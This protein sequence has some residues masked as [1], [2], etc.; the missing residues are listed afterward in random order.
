MEMKAT[1][2]KVSK[3]FFR[4]TIGIFALIG[5]TS[6]AVFV[7]MQF[8]LLNVKGSIAKRNEFFTNTVETATT[9]N[10]AQ[11]TVVKTPEILSQPCIEDVLSVCVWSD[12]PEWE[13]VRGGLLKDIGHI[14]R[15]SKETGVSLRMIASVVVPEQIRFFTSN[16][17]VFKRWFEPMKLLGTMT[18]FSLGVSGIKL[19][20]ALQIEKHAQD[21]SSQ[22]YPGDTFKDLIAYNENVTNTEEEL[23]NRLT[24]EDD[25]YYSY[26]YTA[27]YIREVEVQWER[28][29]FD[30]SNDPHVLVTL[31][32]I[33]FDKS[34]PN[35]NPLAGGA[36]ITVGGKTYTYGELGTLFYNS[37]ELPELS[38]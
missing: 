11:D 21:S 5:F 32:N 7:A 13:V 33:G 26:L 14:E 34:V 29:G 8:D 15:V 23:Y 30:I 28:A 24:N 19:E 10:P 36:P 6:T 16:R 4:I 17:E 38:L 25:H 3:Y 27:L 35:A 9:T 12:T 31:F 2:R 1:V 20:T 18:K 37:T 22:F